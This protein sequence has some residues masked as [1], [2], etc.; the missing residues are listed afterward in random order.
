MRNILVLFSFTVFSDTAVIKPHRTCPDV[1]IF[2]FNSLSIRNLFPSRF[3]DFIFLN[4]ASAMCR[5]TSNRK[6]RKGYRK[7]RQLIIQ[8]KAE[9]HSE[10]S[11]FYPDRG[12]D[13]DSNWSESPRSIYQETLIPVLL[14]VPLPVLVPVQDLSQPQSVATKTPNPLISLFWR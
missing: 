12:P 4:R 13:Q 1:C 2:Y 14:P 8:R 3:H 6:V 7:G 10:S 5:G 9:Q 11:F